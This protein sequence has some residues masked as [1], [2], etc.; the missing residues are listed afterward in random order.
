M[1]QPLVEQAIPQ[2]IYQYASQQ[3]LGRPQ[4][5]CGPR[6]ASM[7]SRLPGSI[8]V[9]VGGLL[10]VVF[11]FLYDNIFSWWSLW[12]QTLLPG[13]GI[14]WIATGIWLL[15]T[16]LLYPPTRVFICSDG[17][18]YATRK[19]E[20]VPWELI[21]GLWKIPASSQTND[22]A[23]AYTIRRVDGKTFEL[24]TELSNL[25]LLG[26]RLE[27]EVTRRLLPRAIATYK[28]GAPLYFGDI[29]VIPQGIS[30]RRGSKLLAWDKVENVMLN[31]AT[32]SIHRKGDSRAW[33][34]MDI[35]EVPNASIFKG[36]VDYILRE[37][38]RNQHPHIAA[39]NE[40]NA[41]CFGG[42]SISRQEIEL[43]DNQL[44]LPWGEVAGIGVGENEVI[45]HA[46]G[47]VQGWYILP[48]W[49][50]SDMPRLQELVEYIMRGKP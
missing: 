47:K 16:P 14:A 12:Q 1:G 20:P 44:R 38:A 2:D 50:L 43:H 22:A 26:E 21:M 24:A 37:H 39:F 35:A 27:D 32:V 41:I 11:F 7:F 6:K 31:D 5:A 19:K 46:R 25:A 48:L 23:Y 30:T 4:A 13:I 18:I 34:T 17:L 36:I 10:I 3:R 40:G 15:L 9:L 29:A 42:L 49:R 8:C 28:S 33:E 45:I